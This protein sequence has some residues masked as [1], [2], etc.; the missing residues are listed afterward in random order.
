MGV[1]KALLA[2][3]GVTFLL[4]ALLHALLRRR[5]AWVLGALALLPTFTFIAIDPSV[6]TDERFYIL[7]LMTLGTGFIAA[8]A[9]V[10]TGLALQAL[11]RALNL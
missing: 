11:Q 4:S 5:R 10:V 6:A 9:G 3:M 1:G 7:L 8:I 2:V